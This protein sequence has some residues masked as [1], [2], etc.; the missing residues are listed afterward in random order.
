M[1][2]G[3]RMVRIQE[4][5]LLCLKNLKHTATRSVKVKAGVRTPEIANRPPRTPAVRSPAKVA[6]FIPRG[7]GVI[8]AMAI[9]LTHCAS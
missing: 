6:Q 8:S 1:Q 9:K 7:P 5:I 3:F 4:K 2:I